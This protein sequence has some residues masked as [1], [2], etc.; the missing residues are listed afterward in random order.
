[1]LFIDLIEHYTIDMKSEHNTIV[2]FDYITTN[3]LL[4]IYLIFE[5]NYY[6]I[7]ISYL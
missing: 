3:K 1:M 2:S 5:S 4:K 6:V 7:I